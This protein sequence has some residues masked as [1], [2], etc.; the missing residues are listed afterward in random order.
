MLLTR[1]PWPHAR[2][3]LWYTSCHSVAT[4]A[5]WSG[6]VDACM[7]SSEALAM[8]SS[9][10]QNFHCCLS[11]LLLFWWWS[12]TGFFDLL[13]SIVDPSKGFPICMFC[14][15]GAPCYNVLGLLFC[16]LL[17]L[18]FGRPGAHW[19]SCLVP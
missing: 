13:L 4:Q 17:D 10:M 11:V 7:N 3:S 5:N 16:F 12:T 2:H 18:P 6:V 15:F 9:H 1:I 19:H 14:C 8:L